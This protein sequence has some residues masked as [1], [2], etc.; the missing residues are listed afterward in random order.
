MKIRKGFVSNSSSTS[1]TITN[2]TDKE[3]TLVDFVKET[4]HLIEDFKKEYDW[5]KDDKDFCQEKLLISAKENNIIFKPNESK[6]CIFGDEDGTLVG[7]VY[8]YM[9]RDIT[10]SK[11]FNVAFDEFLR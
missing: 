6:C 7:H 9:L 10:G 2:L 3:K 5:H 1:F 11:S 8:D 4:P